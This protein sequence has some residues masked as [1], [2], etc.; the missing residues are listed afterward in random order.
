MKHYLAY[1]K[2]EDWQARGKESA[3]HSNAETMLNMNPGDQL[4]LFTRDKIRDTIHVVRRIDIQ[5]RKNMRGAEPWKYGVFGSGPCLQPSKS[6][7]GD[8]LEVFDRIATKR[9]TN[10]KSKWAGKLAQRVQKPRQITAES[11]DLLWNEWEKRNP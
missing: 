5:E 10:L 7:K 11:A 1:W 9:G 8:W 3:Y 4:W 6:L 2:W